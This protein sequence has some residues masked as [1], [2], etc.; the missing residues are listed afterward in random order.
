[1]KAEKIKTLHGNQ[2]TCKDVIYIKLTC[3]LK[4]KDRLRILFGKSLKVQQEIYTMNDEV[5]IITEESR[6]YTD[7]LQIPIPKGWDKD[8]TVNG[9]VSASYEHFPSPSDESNIM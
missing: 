2:I 3:K 7:P 4:L 9:K 8:W 6:H 1:M 5:E